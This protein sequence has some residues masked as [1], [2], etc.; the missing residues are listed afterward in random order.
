MAHYWCMF[1]LIF[2][3]YHS[4][5]PVMSCS[6]FV[7]IRHTLKVGPW[8]HYLTLS[9]SVVQKRSWGCF[10]ASW[11]WSLCVPPSFVRNWIWNLNILACCSPLIAHR[12]P[13]LVGAVW[14]PWTKAARATLRLQ[15]SRCTDPQAQSN[16][17]CLCSG[18]RCFSTSAW[19]PPVR[20]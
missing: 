11:S 3:K 17:G 4:F 19:K 13:W 8:K 12:W 9:W 1:V 5:T 7:F 10:K 2:R 20:L 18:A 14:W 6:L 16:R 15:L